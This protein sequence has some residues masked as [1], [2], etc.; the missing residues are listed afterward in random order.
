LSDKITYEDKLFQREWMLR[1]NSAELADG[2]SAARVALQVF[3]VGSDAWCEILSTLAP[4][5]DSIC[6]ASARFAG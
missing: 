1:V 5:R 6:S 2:K 3:D 4:G